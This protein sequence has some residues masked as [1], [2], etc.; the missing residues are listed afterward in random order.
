MSL[1]DIKERV[2]IMQKE[3]DLEISGTVA[4]DTSNLMRLIQG[5]VMPQVPTHATA[6]CLTLT[7]STLFP[8]MVIDSFLDNQI[9]FSSH[10]S[11]SSY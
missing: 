8:S 5:T 9:H 11:I 1:E 10:P 3:L 2:D 6:T 4:A 7:I